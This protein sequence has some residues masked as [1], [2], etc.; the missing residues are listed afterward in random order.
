MGYWPQINMYELQISFPPLTNLRQIW[1]FLKAWHNGI[2]TSGT[3]HS[4]S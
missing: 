3:R 4:N 2:S 1:V